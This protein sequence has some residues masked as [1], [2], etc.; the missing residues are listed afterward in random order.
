MPQVQQQDEFRQTASRQRRR[1]RRTA[2]PEYRLMDDVIIPYM[3]ETKAD[4]K[5]STAKVEASCAKPLSAFFRQMF[6]SEITGAV[7]RQY[8]RARIE[9]DEVK[10]VTVMRELALASKAINH[11]ISEWDWNL[12]NPFAGRLISDKD[13]KGMK[14]RGVREVTKEE[15]IRLLTACAA[16]GGEFWL[17]VGDM[18]AFAFN[19]GL[20][21]SEILGLRWWQLAGDVITMTPETQKSNRH[22]ECVMNAAAL[23]VISRRQQL[24]ELVFHVEGEPIHRRKLQWAVEQLRTDTGVRFVFSDTRKSC[25]QRILNAGHAIEEVQYQLRHADKRT[26]QRSY[27]TAPV[28]RLRAAVNDI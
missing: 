9:T 25:G 18:L 17:T 4:K 7:V 27:V 16:R 5:P 1:R 21:M 19:T 20:R 15:E 6:I 26:T 28:D 3:R 2:M 24:G 22:S 23:T 14:P 11:A 12:L 13:R 8:R 10:P